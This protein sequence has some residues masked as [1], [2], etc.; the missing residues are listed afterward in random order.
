MAAQLVLEFEGV[1]E[2]EYD[3]VNAA[4][5][6]DPATG[7]GDW[8]EGIVSHAAGLRDDGIF[9]VTEVWDT[10]EHQARFM[11]HRLAQALVDGGITSPPVAII[12]IE[13]SAHHLPGA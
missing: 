11:E 5:G 13:L 12:W 7:T 9:V 1:T 4:L 10:P 6:L 3:A 8:P 2:A